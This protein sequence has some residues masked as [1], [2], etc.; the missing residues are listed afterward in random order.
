MLLTL[1]FLTFPLAP[2]AAQQTVP[3]VPNTPRVTT[4]V[5][6]IDTVADS[7]KRPP[8]APRRALVY[9]LLLPGYSQAR[10]NRPTASVVFAAAEVLFIGMARKS[11]L[12]LREAKA[13]KRDS[14]ATSFTVDPVT[15]AVT[16]TAYVR[17][18]LVARLGARHTHYEDWIAAVIFNHIIAGADAYVAANLWDFKANVALDPSTH[19]AT[20]GG[21]VAF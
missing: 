14:V 17:S 11:S 2:V 3:P 8:I 1:C 18:P 15:G 10:L 7:L 9:S 13:A 16:P 5:N 19:S 4:P 21:S 20:L 6:A 12:D